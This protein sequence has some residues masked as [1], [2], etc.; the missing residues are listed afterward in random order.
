MLIEGNKHEIKF[1][2]ASS[3]STFTRCPAKYFFSRL[4]GY[5]TI[6]SNHIY[7]DFGTAMH[8][9]LPLCY[10]DLSAGI[11]EFTESWKEYSHGNSDD[12]R[13]PGN[14][15]L[16]LQDFHRLRNPNVCP[17]EIL[18][19]PDVV[20]PTKD[21]ISL[22]EVPFAIDIGVPVPAIGR[23]DIPIRWK[24]TGHIFACD[25][26]TTAEI[27]GRFFDSFRNSAQT[28]LYT[29]ALHYLTGEDVKGMAIEAIRVSKARCETQIMPLYIS[30]YQIQMFTEYVS[31]MMDRL[32]DC[33]ENQQWPKNICSCNGYSQ[34]GHP[35]STCEYYN[36]CNSKNW[37]TQAA[38]YDKS[39]P[40]APFEI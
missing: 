32:L 1:I 37:E 10:N 20:E 12:K 4:E 22:F 29:I 17:Y 23:I 13:N 26:K 15:M 33:N 3:I 35:T 5:S 40:F 34:Y 38:G 9:A 6:G 18:E 16:M 11:K 8:R 7:L 27:S 19:F 28:I 14:A 24:S 21:K 25:Y 39:E 31:S 2:D 30:D 36:L